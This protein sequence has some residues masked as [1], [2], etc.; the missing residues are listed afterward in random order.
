LAG[1]AKDVVDLYGSQPRRHVVRCVIQQ[2]LQAAVRG[3]RATPAFAATA[4]ALV[5]GCAGSASAPELSAGF[6]EVV[7][8]Q[9]EAATGNQP[10]R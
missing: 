2:L 6:L 1:I 10:D 4:A 5:A 8:Q 3:P 7:A 9:L